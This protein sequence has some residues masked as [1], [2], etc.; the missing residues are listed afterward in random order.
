[1]G[2]NMVSEAQKRANKKFNREKMLSIT[3]RLH[4]VHDAELI[5]IYEAIP[6]KAEWLRECLKKEGAK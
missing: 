5:A 2:E 6:N 3:F 4:R 1:M